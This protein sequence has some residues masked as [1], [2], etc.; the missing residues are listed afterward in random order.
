MLAESDISPGLALA[1]R[2][3]TRSGFEVVVT[4]VSDRPAVLSEQVKARIG[5]LQQPERFKIEALSEPTEKLLEHL[6]HQDGLRVLLLPGLDQLNDQRKTLLRKVHATVICFEAHLG[7]AADPER[8]WLLGEDTN[9]H[10][11]WVREHLAADLELQSTQVEQLTPGNSD[12]DSSHAPSDWVFLSVDDK[13]LDATFKLAKLAI[14]SA[15]G[16]VMMVRGESHWFEWL[17]ERKLPMLASKFIPQMEREERRH[18][19]ERLQKYSKLDFEF[20]VL[21]CSATFLASFGLL[22][23]S[24]A[25]IIGA[26][27]VAPLMTPI[28]GAGLSLA[29]GNRPLFRESLKTIVLGFLA[30]L[31]TSCLFGLLVRWIAPSMLN[32]DG[33][34]IVLTDEMWSRTYPTGIDFLVGLVGGSAAAFARTRTHLADALAGAAIAAALVPP[35]AT[36]GLH[37]SVLSMQVAPPE[38]ATEVTNLIYGPILLFVANMLTIMIGSASVLWACGARNDSSF[39]VRERWSTRTVM[40]LMILTAMVLVWIIQ[41]PIR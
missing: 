41:H 17:T 36:A 28:L 21:I 32:F 9:G 38:N 30:A 8:L 24:A 35:I 31:V 18:L 26:M 27:L 11:N 5:R 34:K 1:E 12:T 10:V 40:L 33:T 13:K 39:S 15:V 23:N 19:A 3:A 22:Q 4:V 16:P 2:I 25:V 7:L 6:D 14:E 20:L 29:H 37:L